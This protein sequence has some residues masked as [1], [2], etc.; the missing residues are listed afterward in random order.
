[1][2]FT[3]DRNRRKNNQRG[4]SIVELLIAL[5]ILSISILAFYQMMIT[6]NMLITEQYERRTAIEHAQGWVEKMAYYASEFD[7]VPRRIFNHS[8]VDT[9]VY[10]EDDRDMIIGD[11]QIHV[12]HSFDKDPQS[13]VPLYSEVSVVITWESYSEREH[14]VEVRTRL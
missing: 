4:M 3:A 1:M 13:G 7:T 8:F 2:I 5:V 10:P 11:C 12:E 9:I 14:R 6:G